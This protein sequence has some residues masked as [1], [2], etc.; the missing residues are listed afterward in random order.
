MIPHPEK[1]STGGADAYFISGDGIGV[2]DGVGEWD[3]FGLNPRL[4]AEQLMRSCEHYTRIITFPTAAPSQRAMNIL[5]AAY[6]DTT[7]FGSS[8]ALVACLDEQGQRLGIANLGDSTCLI[9]RRQQPYAMSL[10]LRTREQQHS[11]NCPFQLSRLPQPEHFPDLLKDGKITLVRVLKQSSLLPQDTPSMANGYTATLHEGDLI[12]LGTDGVFDN[13]FDHEVC[14]LANL[15][16]SPF[17]AALLKNPSLV[18]SAESVA[19]A[20]AHAAF[21]RS[22]DLKAKSP[23]AKNARQSGTHYQGGKMDDITV[24]ACWVVSDT[25][26]VARPQ[27]ATSRKS[28]ST[29]ASSSDASLSPPQAET[30]PPAT[31]L[32]LTECAY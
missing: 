5:T 26:E 12:I 14:N 31:P 30:L 24:V 8:T 20:I 2:A 22:K 1:A 6:D 13:L 4:F 25:N 17:E 21:H 29:C 23:F 28:V 7:A 9:L 3:S 19:R 16:M 10:V 32:T 11:F 18:T 15:T 27:S